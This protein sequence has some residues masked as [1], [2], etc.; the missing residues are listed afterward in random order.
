MAAAPGSSLPFRGVQ[1]DTSAYLTLDPSSKEIR[2]LRLHPGL[3]ND[4]IVCSLGYSTFDQEARDRVPYQA[5]SYCWGDVND[6]TP[7]KL[8]CPVSKNARFTG[9]KVDHALINYNVTRNLYAALRSLRLFGKPRILWIDAVCMNQADPKEKTHQVGLMNLIYSFAE[10]VVVWLGEPDL[11][12][13][14]VV[15]CQQVLE[16]SITDCVP[17]FDYRPRRDLPEYVARLQRND[18][19]RLR[20][21]F[22]TR[23]RADSQ[24]Q[25]YVGQQYTRKEDEVLSYLHGTH[26]KPAER[27]LDAETFDWKFRASLEHVLSRPYFRRMWVYQEVLLAPV[28]TEGHRRVTVRIG[29]SSLG[30]G[31]LID[32]VR[33]SSQS[34]KSVSSKFR[35]KQE[36]TQWFEDAWSHMGRLTQVMFEKYYSRTLRFVATDPRDKFFALLHLGH[37]TQSQVRTNPLLSP[38]YEIPLEQVIVNFHRAGIYLPLRVRI[39]YDTTRVH[40]W[41]HITGYRS[42]EPIDGYMFQLGFWHDPE[43]ADSR[44]GVVTDVPSPLN[45]CVETPAQ[46]LEMARVD[47]VVEDLKGH[48]V[49]TEDDHALFRMLRRFLERL[50]SIFGTLLPD[51]PYDSLTEHIFRLLGITNKRSCTGW[52]L[53][54]L[55]SLP[56][57]GGAREV[58][59]DTYIQ[60]ARAFLA[61]WLQFPNPQICVASNK[62]IVLTHVA[63]QHGDLIVVLYGSEIPMILTP[64]KLQTKGYS[65]QI[66]PDYKII[67]SC[68]ICTPGKRLLIPS[69]FNNMA[70]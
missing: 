32:I 50:V 59:N 15:R 24:L 16:Q 4:P 42:L 30:W 52:S 14:I 18:S 8:Y 60:D 53:F 1:N 44:S 10:E 45:D 63:V 48:L 11:N 33:L 9:L 29:R 7:I 58:F 49:Q 70:L 36:N 65:W 19:I 6:T 56:E 66:G 20:D 69:E 55:V 22:L 28:T 3:P 25:T 34:K 39:R 5:L 31:D 12:S 40:P 46:G 47:R 41:T 57:Q 37:N 67:G 13:K 43:S 54:S 17:L 2:Y 35:P 68:S 27:V 61:S 38:N 23:M 51:T 62:D 64:P 21:Q 26:G